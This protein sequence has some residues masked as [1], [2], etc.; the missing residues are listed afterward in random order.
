M[1]VGDGVPA[2]GDGALHY[3]YNGTEM[4]ESVSM[5]YLHAGQAKN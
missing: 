5:W 3:G 2:I 4:V 1:K